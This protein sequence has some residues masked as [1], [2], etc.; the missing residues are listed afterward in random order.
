MDR[1]KHPTDGRTDEETRLFVRPSVCVSD[2]SL[3]LMR[4][5]IVTGLKKLTPLKL[6]TRLQ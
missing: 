4:Q 3:T 5:E 1:D 2:E 6:L